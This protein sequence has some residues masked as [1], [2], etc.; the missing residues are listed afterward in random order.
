MN[1]RALLR[2]IRCK[3]I[4]IERVT[5]ILIS[6]SLITN[7]SYG[8][9]PSLNTLLNPLLA[10]ATRNVSSSSHLPLYSVHKLICGLFVN[11]P[12]RPLSSP[13][14]SPPREFTILP[15]PPRLVF[16]PSSAASRAWHV[17]EGG[18]RFFLVVPPFLNVLY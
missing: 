1:T 18:V 10:L 14:Q 13:S 6:H 2:D 3:N 8:S 11:D 5:L 16:P 17:D 12:F 7:P 15:P 4:L 9:L